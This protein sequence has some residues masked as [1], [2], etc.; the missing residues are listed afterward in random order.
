LI[1]KS[2]KT[3]A[4]ENCIPARPRT[5][6]ERIGA[7]VG[8]LEEQEE[9]R[10]GFEWRAPSVAVAPRAKTEPPCWQLMQSGH[11]LRAHEANFRDSLRSLKG[12]IPE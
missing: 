8:D 9:I 3:C 5:V 11:S 10:A 2:R 6:D 12:R 7:N 1:R 4:Q